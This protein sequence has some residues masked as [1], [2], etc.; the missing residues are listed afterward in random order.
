M[1]PSL[2]TT[3]TELNVFVCSFNRFASGS[4]YS[5]TY[6]SLIY[7]ERCFALTCNVY[8]VDEKKEFVDTAIFS[9]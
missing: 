8:K 4:R 7:G 9:A 1:F 3:K 5:S 6:S 2:S